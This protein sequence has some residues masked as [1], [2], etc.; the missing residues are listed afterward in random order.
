MTIGSGSQAQMDIACREAGVLDI[1]RAK[2]Y[3]DPFVNP[4]YRQAGFVSL[5]LGG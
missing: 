3:N 1:Q 5:S 2:E 4:A